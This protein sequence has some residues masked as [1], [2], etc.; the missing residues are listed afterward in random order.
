MCYDACVAEGRSQRMCAAFRAKFNV[1]VLYAAMVE[2][3]DTRDLKSTVA[4][5]VP[6]GK[7]ID[8][9]RFFWFPSSLFSEHPSETSLRFCWRFLSKEGYN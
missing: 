9:S 4:N 8:I 2:L 5:E 1:V 7:T 6:N 3:V